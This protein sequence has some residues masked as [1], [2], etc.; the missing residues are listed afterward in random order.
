[1]LHIQALYVFLTEDHIS[2]L[3]TITG[4]LPL[5]ELICQMPRFMLYHSVN[6]IS[7]VNFHLSACQRNCVFPTGLYL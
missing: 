5:R 6:E 1:M 4:I 7:V 2:L 3:D